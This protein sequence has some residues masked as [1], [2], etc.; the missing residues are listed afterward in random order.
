MQLLMTAHA[1]LRTSANPQ[2]GPGLP[3]GICVPPAVFYQFGSFCMEGQVS[4]PSPLYEAKQDGFPA[5]FSPRCQQ[6]GFQALVCFPVI[7][8]VFTSGIHC[9]E[10]R[11]PVGATKGHFVGIGVVAAD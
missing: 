8:F 11:I 9:W 7:L 10:V 1:V 2:L 5:W 3:A 6:V 4:Y